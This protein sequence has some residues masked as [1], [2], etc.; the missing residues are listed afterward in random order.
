MFRPTRHR[1]RRGSPRARGQRGQSLVEFAIVLP[2]ILFLTLITLDFGRVYLGWIN[3]QN[4]ARI[5]ANY[6][7][8]NPDAWG[9]I[10][11][12]KALAQYRNQILADAAATN[13]Q[14]PVVSGVTQVPTPTFTD[15]N[16]DG[17]ATGLGDKVNVQLTC[18]FNVITPVISNVIGGTVAVSADSSFP[19]KTGMTATGSGGAGG[20]VA[21][22]AAFTGNGTVSPTGITGVAPFNVDFRDTSGG[23]PTNWAWDL[24]DSTTSTLQ[25]PLVHTYTIPGTYNVTLVASNLQGSSTAHMTVTVTSGSTVDFTATPLT[26]TAPLTVQFTDAS[27]AGGLSYLWSFGAGEGT[28]TATNPTHQY[29]NAGTYTVSLTVTFPSPTGAITKTKTNYVSVNLCLVPSLNGVK[30]DN[31]TSVWRS[32]P[33]NFTGNVIRD[34]GAPNGNFTIT[35]QSL[36]AG[37]YAP[38][39]SNVTVS[40]P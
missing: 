22:N 36:T 3:L 35:A 31:A 15:Q 5:A 13:C 10:P 28:S 6:A 9:A 39:G 24:G 16:G 18:T 8:N 17:D 1:A 30:F 29:N 11:D 26:G 23:S 7:A 38:C 33:Y 40:R 14:L 25:D 27:S 19:V 2:I 20:G 4:M 34:A 37:S 12:T 21:P 32:S